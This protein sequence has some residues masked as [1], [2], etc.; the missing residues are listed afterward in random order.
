[1]EILIETVSSILHIHINGE[2]DANSSIELDEVIKKAIAQRRTKIMIDCRELRYIS[3][4]GVGVFL[5][6]LDDVKNLG[7]RFV[8][9]NMSAGVF[10]IFE[11]LGLHKLIDI[12]NG[13]TEAQKIFD[14]S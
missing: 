11:I 6:H 4:A 5:S 2:L 1:M 10:S 12:V 14:E 9:Y 3:S 7:G 8:F 13:Y